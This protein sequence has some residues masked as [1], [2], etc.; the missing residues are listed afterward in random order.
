MADRKKT[1]YSGV[2][3]R[4]AKTKTF[5]GKPDIAFDITYRFEGKKIWEKVGWLSEGYSAKLAADVLSERI[6]AKRHGDELPQQKKKAITFEKLAEEYLKWSS[7]NKSREG[8]DDKSRYENHLKARFDKK[9]LDEI[10]LLDLERM[11]SEMSKVKTSA[12]KTISPKTISHC[13]ALI[14]AMYNKAM[15]WDMY[16][17]KNPIPKKRRGD[18]K[19]LMPTIQNARDRF[20]SMKEAEILLKELKRNPQ[21]KKEY[22]ELKDTKLH[23][24]TLLSLQTGA[25]AGEIFSLKGN[26]VDLENDLITLRDT[27]NTETR[28]APMT[29]DVKKML[30][31]RMPDNSNDYIFT[32]KDGEKI[33]E[34]SNAFQRIVDRLGFNDG[35]EDS[36]ERVVFHTCRHTFASWLAIQGTPLYTIAKLM[37]HKSISMSERY[38]HLSPDH[39]KDAVNVLATALKKHKGNVVE[40]KAEG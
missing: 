36:R 33:N 7:K 30:K 40:I 31:R 23:D 3:E 8:I 14:R 38:A 21:I 4:A 1:I 10:T 35:A 29:S 16:N 39:K 17:G 32:D 20:F 28:Y 37:G 34:V 24:I 25:R 15:D 26:D 13:L 18:K 27:K 5:K 9:R 11:K 19:G 22:K 2:Y 6:H 12:G